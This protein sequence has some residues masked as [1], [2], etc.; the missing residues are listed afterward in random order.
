MKKMFFELQARFA[1]SLLIA[2][3]SICGALHASDVAMYSVFKAKSFIQTNS[4][5]AVVVDSPSFMFQAEVDSSGDNSVTSASLQL[6]DSSVQ[7]L[8]SD[9]GGN[10]KIK[11]K[12]ATTGSMDAAYPDGTYMMIIQTAH[13]GNRTNALNLSGGLYPTTPHV[14]NFGA[15]QAVD[16]T[17][18]FSL[19]WD[20]ISG[21]TSND[22]VQFSLRDCQGN[23]FFTTPQPGG[24]GALNGLA[25][26]ATI[27]GG[28][29]RAGAT[30]SG[31]LLVARASTFDTNSYA[32][33]L[34][35]AA[36]YKAV[37][38]SLM[39][40]GAQTGCSIGSFQLVFNF[41]Q[42][43]FG[44]GTSGS[45]SFPQNISYYFGLFNVDH[46]T[47]YP[48]S[49]TF[50]GPSGS[51]LN[52]TTNQYNGSS[53]GSSAFYATPQVYTPPFPPGG[54]YTVNYKGSSNN[55]SLADPNAIN[56]QVLIVPTVVL[57]SSNVVT[58]INWVYKNPNGTTIPA[59]PFMNSIE[60]RVQ[61]FSGTLYDTEFNNNSSIPPSMTNHILSQTVFWTN[62][63]SIEMVFGDTQGNQYD[64]YWNRSAQP[65]VI[66]TPTNL[67]SATQG[68]SYSFL[69]SA[70]GGSQQF[71][72]FAASNS[73]P[74]GLSLNGITGEIS[75]TPSQSG[76]FTFNVMATDT[77][78]Q[79]TNRNFSMLINAAA[80]PRPTLSSAVRLAN[81]QFKFRVNGTAGQNY[82]LQSS[83][84][85]FNWTSIITINSPSSAF[86]VID[87]NGANVTRRFYRVSVGP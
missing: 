42:G 5:A 41:E 51:G 70:T 71:T 46:D 81:G 44:S 31:Q 52:N 9:G 14:S 27:P 43:T 56:Q 77:A 53:F 68:S 23:E 83:T 79:S 7:L 21:A 74:M 55:F 48:D 60:V 29:L 35:L 33:A 34:G 47:N 15:A 37:Q 1:A 86:D 3:L 11:Q 57:N 50:T 20:A 64:S 4:G 17:S 38:I 30:Y 54:I 6:P 69:L 25:T 84:D 76:S 2:S 73:L 87:P 22:F 62:V 24:A 65:V 45:I 75:G 13:D 63:T 72:W 58:Q 18:D 78:S 36:Y 28:T 80:A 82:T 8:E 19:S 39:T 61:G 67:P 10:L 85:L 32:G 59:Q 40:T 49:V 66:T 26:M 12:F 16:P